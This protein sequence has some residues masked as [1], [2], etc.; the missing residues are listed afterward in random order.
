MAHHQHVEVFFESVAGVRPGG[1][2]AAGKHVCLAADF[3]DV[4]SMAAACT[5]CVKGMD[6]AAFDRGDGVFNEAGFVERVGVDANLHIHLI[7]YRQ[8][9]IDGGRCSTPILMQLEAAGT[10]AH[11]LF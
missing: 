8:A 11:L 1:I 10:C 3:D 9:G 6:R 5:L 7:G 2:G 4:W